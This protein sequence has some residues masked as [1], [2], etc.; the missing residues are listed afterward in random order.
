MTAIAI[1]YHSAGG[2]TK[3]L[4]EAVARGVEAEGGTTVSLHAVPDVDHA[5]LIGADAIIFGCPTYMGSASAPFKAFMDGTSTIWALQGWRDKLAAAFTHSAAPSGDKLGT[6]T[7][8]AVFA[9]Q[10]GMMWIGLG[11]PP[12]YAGVGGEADEASDTNRLGSHLGA[13]AQSPPGVRSVPDSDLATAE[14]LGRRVALAVR[15]WARGAATAGAIASAAAAAAADEEAEAAMKAEV[16]MPGRHPAAV[17][18]Q[19]PPLDRPLLPA[20]LE[21]TNLRLL[22][23]RPD[24]FEH[25]LIVCATLGHTQLEVVTASEPLYFGH[26][27]FSDE[28]ALALPCGDP[29]VDRVPLRTFI[30]DA[31][32]GADLG[33]YNHRIG[34][35][36][37]HPVGHMHWPGRLRP[38]YEPFDFPPGLRR[39][40]LSLVFCATAHVASSAPALPPP[41][42]RESDIKPYADPP[43]PMMIAAI[44]GPATTIARIGTTELM[45]VERRGRIAPARGCWVVVLKADSASPHDAGDLIRVP[46][47]AT[48]DARGI[49]RALVLA[50]PYIGPDAPPPSWQG[51]P[52]PPFPPYEDAPPGALPLRLGALTIEETRSG[53]VAIS[54]D[55]ATAAV[56]R[57]WLARMLFRVALHGL[58]LGYIE[59]YGGLFIDDHPQRG[60]GA[61]ELGLRTTSGRKALAIPA[62]EAIAVIERLYR[63]VAPPGYRE[64][65]R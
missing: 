58:R 45:L 31:A 44:D 63:A 1:V 15:R 32:T 8:L 7:Q 6:L 50:D 60:D 24:R 55:G 30:S 65:L 51:L 29:M 59:T 47:G 46:A 21:R 43:P 3:A 12:T 2:R 27:A 52:P 23:A 54:L 13:M 36:V 25:H 16:T 35:L 38:P 10:H 4:A 17:H 5:V 40:G 33:R 53:A 48:L 22:M 18:W 41:A 26:V 57:Y 19:F 64:R 9:A 11:L 49:S 20:P 56:P 28:Y 62:D 37:L 34:D 61:I 39:C 42:G 14:H